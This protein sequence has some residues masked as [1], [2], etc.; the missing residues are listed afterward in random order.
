MCH[1]LPGKPHAEHLLSP[2]FPHLLLVKS[3]LHAGVRYRYNVHV[4]VH[5]HRY[6]TVQV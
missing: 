3:R 6:M 2:D 5:V 4:H 1:G